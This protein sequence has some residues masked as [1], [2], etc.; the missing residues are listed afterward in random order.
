MTGAIV[1]HSHRIDLNVASLFYT[2]G[3]QALMYKYIS[4]CSPLTGSPQIYPSFAATV[5]HHAHTVARS[6]SNTVAFDIIRHVYACIGKEELSRGPAVYSGRS[7][8]SEVA[9]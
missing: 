5:A 7:D 8:R 2:Q 4:L 1:T 6:I 9:R 3:L